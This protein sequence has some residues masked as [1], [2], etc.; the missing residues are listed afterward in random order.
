M[1]IYN[2][3]KRFVPFIRSGKK[4]HTI[5]A[6]RRRPDKPGNTL[7][8][9]SGL[10]QKGAAKLIKRAVCTRIEEIRIEYL[11]PTGAGTPFAILPAVWIDGNQL[12]QSECEALARRDGFRDFP[13]MMAFWNGRLPFT[14]DVIHWK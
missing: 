8:L 3:H 1:G 12:D 11:G 7:H 10:R 14:G 2:F 4:K 13:D 6:K 9:Y 5:R